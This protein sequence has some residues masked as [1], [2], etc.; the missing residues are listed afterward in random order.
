L[1]NRFH[2]DVS[3]GDPIVGRNGS[4]AEQVR[5]AFHLKAELTVRILA[6]GEV[7]AVALRQSLRYPD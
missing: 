5:A 2:V 1:Q 4:M 7:A 6:S 3:N